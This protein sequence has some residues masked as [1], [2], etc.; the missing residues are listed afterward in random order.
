ME[1]AKDGCRKKI[2]LHGPMVILL[3][4][5]A[6]DFVGD[7]PPTDRNLR[8]QTNSI[9]VSSMEKAVKKTAGSDE[10]LPPKQM[11]RHS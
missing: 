9:C 3:R 10:R 5:E 6:V 8:L 11:M 1:A 2:T 7:M 4:W